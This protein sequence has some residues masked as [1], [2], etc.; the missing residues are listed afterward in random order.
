[1]KKLSLQIILCICCVL[2]GCT[3]SSK[4][5]FYSEHAIFINLDTNETLFVKEETTRVAPA[6]LTKMMSA[7][8]AIE[9]Y[10]DYTQILTIDSLSLEQLSLENSSLAGFSPNEKV[11][12]EDLLYGTLLSSGGE[13]TITLAKAVASSEEQFVSLMN[14]KANQL[15]LQDTHF[16]NAC[17]FDDENHYSTVKDLSALLSY[18]L[19][20]ETFKK[21]FTTKQYNTS[22]SIFHPDGILLSSTMFENMSSTLTNGEIIGG[23]T[24]FTSNAGLCLASL[25][26]IDNQEYIFVTTNAKGNHTTPQY[27]ILD[28]IKAYQTIAT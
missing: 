21:I 1:M 11:T 17:G 3:T 2:T 15:Q 4:N 10:Q 28:A 25:A 5:G 23:K 16:S 8:I 26:R 9:Y 20:N 22:P 19:K 14:Q 7:I 24:G 27:N 6:S 12:I 18:C 13:A